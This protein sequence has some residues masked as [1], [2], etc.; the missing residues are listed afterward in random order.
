MAINWNMDI[1]SLKNLLHKKRSAVRTTGALIPA[2]K[3]IWRGSIIFLFTFAALVVAYDAYI[4]WEDVYT[5]QNIENIDI[6]ERAK[7]MFVDRTS[8]DSV[9]KEIDTRASRFNSATTSA[10]IRNPFNNK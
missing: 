1:S 9:M 6:G 4:F 7:V 8:F 10:P 5:K 2:T 3:K